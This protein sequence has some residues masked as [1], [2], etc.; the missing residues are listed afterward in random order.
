MAS[1]EAATTIKVNGNSHNNN[2]NNNNSS[3]L[4][5][6]VH[7]SSSS[8]TSP[9]DAEAALY[10]ELWHACAGPLVTVPREGERVFYFPQGH[11]EQ[12]EASTNQ[13]ADQHM[14][15]YDLPSK[16][17]CR[18]INVQLKA[19][20]DTDEVFAQ[21]TLLPEQNQDE[22]AVEKEPPLPPP[23]RFHVHSFCKTLTASDTS[24]HGGFSVLRRHADECLPP[25][26]MSKQPPTQELVA[27]DLHAN[28][29]RFRH[30]F[31]GLV[32]LSSLFHTTNIWNL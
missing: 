20:P 11:I 15:V 16:I 24:T 6:N 31:R 17:L 19:E 28:E 12:V 9:K 32:L 5:N 27:K 25:L 2:N 10:R 7:S 4:N 14:P 8:S 30:I 13:V 23:P 29:W 3:E 22:S 18:V 26:D 21:I 1:S